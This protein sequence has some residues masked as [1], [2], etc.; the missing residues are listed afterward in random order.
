MNRNSK[1]I[2]SLYQALCLF[3]LG[4]TALALASSPVNAASPTTKGKTQASHHSSQKATKPAQATYPTTQTTAQPAYA[5]TRPAAAPVAAAPVE[6]S[7]TFGEMVAESMFGDVYAEP[8]KWQEL[9]Y[10]NLFSKGWNKPWVSPPAGGG[11]APRMGWL[12]AEDGVFYRLSIATFAWQHGTGNYSD[13]YSGM[14]TSYTPV[15]ARFEVR[16]DIG[17]A[18]NRGPSNFAD[19]IV[20]PR[21]LLSESKEQTQS[22]DLA[23]RTPTGNSY[24]G[25]G[26]A[27]INPQ[28]NFWTN[29]WKGLVVRGGLGFNVPY[30]G[31]I[32]NAGAR[33]T[34]YSNVAIG[35]YFT[36][37]NAAPF[38]DLVLYVSNKFSQVIDNRGPS[39]TTTFSM[40]PGFRD[41]LG[42]NWYLL[43]AVD[44]PVTNPKP[45]DYQV[46]GGIMKVY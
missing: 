43:G 26:Y 12:N 41:H 27:S 5:P 22:L 14:L 39:S 37:H 23:F 4:F 31:E 20:T 21:F 36:E 3:G 7:Y 29:Y 42:D 17:L 33:S 25:Q 9:G 34:F 35:Y 19:F 24:N 16:T 18:S 2:K 10:G 28:Y 11:G 46:F 44:V 38:G 1:P 45:Y 6:R 40:G 8:S 30:S 32:A 13:S 15:S